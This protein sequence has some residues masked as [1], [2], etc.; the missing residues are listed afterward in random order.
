MKIK[1]KE[2]RKIFI[3]RNKEFFNAGL[4][5]NEYSV[6]RSNRAD[7]ACYKDGYFYCFEIKS[8]ADNLKRL[9]KQILTYTKYF[10]FI[11]LVIFK[12]HVK[13]A[14]ELLEKFNY[15]HVGIIEVDFDKNITY[16][17]VR[18]ARFNDKVKPH[19][20]LSQLWKEDIYKLSKDL[21]FNIPE[22]RPKYIFVENL[23]GKLDIPTIKKYLQER[24]RYVYTRKCPSCKSNLVY[25]TSKRNEY[26]NTKTTTS[27]SES[28]QYK[29][30]FE[31][32]FNFD[33][34]RGDVIKKKI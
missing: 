31:C 2:I 8:Q 6:G 27:I 17:N 4:F 1:D 25:N 9:K 26:F 10:D 12:S 14:L 5:L 29:E 23:K 32:G 18:E 7:I 33:Y 13:E 22:Y 16:T 28:V 21:G 34:K 30:C 19:C 11:Y 15:D 20:L 24:L 3:L